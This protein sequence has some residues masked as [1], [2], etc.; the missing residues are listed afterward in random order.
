[1]STETTTVTIGEATT[2]TVTG[3][4]G[5]RGPAGADGSGSGGVTDGD[6]G[7]ITVS[8]SG[9]TWTIDAGAVTYTKLQDVSAT[10]RLLGRDTVGAGD[11]EELTPAAVRTMLN[12]EDG[13]TADQTAAEI[14]AAVKTVDGAASGLDADLLDGQEAA[15]FQPV[16]ADLTTIAAA[17][18]GAVL[19][20]TTASF[21]T[22]DET[23]LDGIE[24]AA[25]ADQTAAE[26]LTAIKTVDGTGSGLDA[27]TV[28]GVEAAALAPLASPTFT[29]VPAAPTATAG[30]N[31]TQIAT[32]AYVD[33][34][35]S[36]AVPKALVD[37]K[38]DLLAGSA[39]DTVARL[40]VGTDGQVLTADSVQALGVK[41]ATPAGGGGGGGGGGWP[42]VGLDPG[43]TNQQAGGANNF[44]F[45]NR[46]HFYEVPAPGKDITIT[47]VYFRVAAASTGG[48]VSIAVY[49]RTTGARLATTGAFV[50]P[51]T[52]GLKSQAL[53]ASASVTA[54]TPLVVGISADATTAGTW[55]GPL[56]ADFDMWLPSAAPLVGG[57][58]TAAHPLPDP[59]P[60]LAAGINPQRMFGVWFK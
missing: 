43:D 55:Y 51:T 27:D 37:A 5:P 52:T 30:T 19:A 4:T 2:V 44:A 38:G 49:N 42:F 9:A 29:G 50:A 13:A 7:D 26:I 35:T 34:A 53:L 46:G 31:T 1:M 21:T 56:S 48:N 6:K 25:T 57:V 58:N 22:A 10:D 45:A 47:T 32:T 60:T 16:D 3:N 39:P 24:T 14:L 54:G 11:V 59:L 12:V 17:N 20:A 15:A 36:A 28:D 8:A 40:P 41:W 23:K 18:N 33:S